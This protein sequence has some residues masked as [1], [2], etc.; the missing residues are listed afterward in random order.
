MKVVCGSNEGCSA[1]LEVYKLKDT[2]Y[3][4]VA[5]KDS[6]T[7]EIFFTNVNYVSS[8]KERRKTIITIGLER[9]GNNISFCA[10]SHSSTIKWY[11]YCGLLLMIPKYT[12]PEIPKESVALKQAIKRM[13][14][15]SK[16]DAS[17]YTML[18]T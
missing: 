10:S 4:N 11:A 3:A 17:T 13:N 14:D 7:T 15:S 9:S 2:Q 1:R 6:M 16:C 5:S 18:Y 8:R 12:I